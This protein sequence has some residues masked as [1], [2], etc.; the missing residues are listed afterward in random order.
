M[1]TVVWTAREEI[2]S[3]GPL[4][5]VFYGPVHRPLMRIKPGSHPSLVAKLLH[6]KYLTPSDRGDFAACQ[7]K[8]RN[9]SDNWK[10][11]T[12][13]FIDPTNRSAV[14]LVSLPGSGN[15]W[16][17]GLLERATGVCTGKAGFLPPSFFHI[18]WGH[19][20]KK[21]SYRLHLF[22]SFPISTALPLILS[23]GLP[24]YPHPQAFPLTSS[25]GHPL[26]LILLPSS[27]GFPLI[28][29]RPCPLFSGAVY[30]DVILREQGFNGEG[31]K[32]GAVLAVKTH[33]WWS[34][35]NN[36]T[37]QATVPSRV[38]ASSTVPSSL[39]PLPPILCR[40]NPQIMVRP[41][42]WSGVRPMLSLQSGTEDRLW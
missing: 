21:P 13:V 4:S 3:S 15:T 42:C 26:T 9:S 6:T 11:G 16:L 25:P 41:S 33:V 18:N 34:G 17:R 35:W 19:F 31:I 36:A 30:C 12:C 24:S 14:A 8:H 32:S 5:A 37:S 27:P 1:L 39:M 2:L 10:L 28:P 40:G 38:C 7:E 29:H 20:K 22:H 23:P